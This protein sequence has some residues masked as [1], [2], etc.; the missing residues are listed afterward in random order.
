MYVWLK[1]AVIDARSKLWT[2]SHVPSPVKSIETDLTAVAELLAVTVKVYPLFQVVGV[3]TR[4]IC[5][6]MGGAVISFDPPPHPTDTIR[7]AANAPISTARRFIVAP[8][9]SAPYIRRMTG[10]SYDEERPRIKGGVSAM[11]RS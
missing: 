3:A 9:K 6:P 8:S 11:T 5:V 1:V 2:S 4:L 7:S 10:L